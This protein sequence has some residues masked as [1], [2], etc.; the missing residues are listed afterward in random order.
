MVYRIKRPSSILLAL[1]PAPDPPCMPRNSFY[2]I[3]CPFD[4]SQY[5]NL[6]LLWPPAHQSCTVRFEVLNCSKFRPKRN[7]MTSTPAER[8]A[9]HRLYNCLP[10]PRAVHQLY[11]I[12]EGLR[13][14]LLLWISKLRAIRINTFEF[15]G[16]LFKNKQVWTWF[17]K[18]K[19][20]SLW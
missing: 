8:M 9:F 15:K 13:R 19:R 5:D 7:T 14:I 6:C 1:C 12:S 16:N 11:S 17:W 20:L 4:C 10:F 3:R 18:F 2:R